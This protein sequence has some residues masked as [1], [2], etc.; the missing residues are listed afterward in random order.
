MMGKL[1]EYKKL[2]EGYYDLL[3]VFM[4]EVEMGYA[5]LFLKDNYR[6]EYYNSDNDFMDAIILHESHINYEEGE[7][8]VMHEI[9][10]HKVRVQDSEILIKYEIK[11]GNGFPIYSGESKI[12][13]ENMNE[14]IKTGTVP[15]CF[16]EPLDDFIDYKDYIYLWQ[17]AT[18][19]LDYTK[20][21]LKKEDK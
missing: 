3:K 6:V 10:F 7:L 2:L 20:L 1:K 14:L 8:E 16:S 18:L 9:P 17:D 19:L 13:C 12:V 11:R 4:K 21:L 15:V 5:R